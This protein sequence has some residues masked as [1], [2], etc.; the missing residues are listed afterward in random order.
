MYDVSFDWFLTGPH[1]PNVFGNDI[2]ITSLLSHGF[3]ICK[4][5]V[6]WDRLSACKVSMLNVVWVK[7]YKGTEK[8]NDEVIMTYF[9]IV[10]TQILHIW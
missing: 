8:H 3:Q 10:G 2:I 5:C 7:L 1:F 9:H 6:I 4:F